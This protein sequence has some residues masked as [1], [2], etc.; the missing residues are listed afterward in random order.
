[1][2]Q[3]SP[4]LL[5]PGYATHRS[6]A[7]T[8]LSD[9]LLKER[10]Y[11]ILDLG[12]PISKNI[13]FWSQFQPKITIADFYRSLNAALP[14]SPDAP[15]EYNYETLLPG[16][17]DARF[18]IILAWDL[19]NYLEHD[20]LEALIGCLS[21]VCRSGT[22]LFALIGFTQQ[23]P[24]DPQ[25]FRIVDREQLAYENRSTS[26]RSC[27][28]YQPRDINRMMAGFRVHNSFILRHGFQEYLFVRE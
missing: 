23:M 8:A 16:G 2:N 1:M 5:N 17:P 9:Q 15:Y 19:F 4:A 7:L 6:L 12:P 11:E 25:V 24:A 13:E 3:T 28:R 20:A 22:F 27:P 18:D 10:S 14:S 21:R 26:V